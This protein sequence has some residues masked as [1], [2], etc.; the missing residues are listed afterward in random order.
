[1][2]YWIPF[3]VFTGTGSA[4]EGRAFLDSRLRG[5]DKL[6][7]KDEPYRND[8]LRGMTGLCRNME[9]FVI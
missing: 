7:G 4:W 5:N 6:R 2:F 8:R 9:F 3:P 1:M